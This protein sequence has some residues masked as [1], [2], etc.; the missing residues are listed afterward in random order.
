MSAEEVQH[1]EKVELEEEIRRGRIVKAM[2]QTEGWLVLAEYIGRRQVQLTNGW[3]QATKLEQFIST[4]QCYN[5]YEDLL[6]YI[7]NTIAA[8]QA[9]H[10]KLYPDETMRSGGG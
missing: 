2:T 9:A 5:T 1:D 7:R 10:A 8:G 6:N 3:K 4:Q